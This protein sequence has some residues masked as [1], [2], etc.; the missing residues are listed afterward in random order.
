MV[1]T[2]STAGGQQQGCDMMEH[3]T[4]TSGGWPRAIQHQN[5]N[6]AQDNAMPTQPLLPTFIL[7]EKFLHFLNIY[8]FIFSVRG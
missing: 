2:E 7:M 6:T 5:T 3:I 8:D 1:S 4:V